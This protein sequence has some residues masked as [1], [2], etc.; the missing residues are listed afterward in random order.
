MGVASLVLGILAV[1]IG[2]FSSGV[3]GWL[4]AI[5]AIIGV[6]MGALGM[7]KPESKG[8]ELRQ[9]WFCLLL[10]WHYALSCMQHA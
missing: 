5:M 7:K 6:V 9:D 10:V 1:L 3:L 8:I 4:G 2:I